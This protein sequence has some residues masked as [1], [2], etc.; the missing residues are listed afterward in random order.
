MLINEFRTLIKKHISE[1]LTCFQN[2]I[3]IKCIKCKGYRFLK[4]THI[5]LFLRSFISFVDN[6]IEIPGNQFA[7]LKEILMLFKFRKW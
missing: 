5:N 1:N 6:G 2:S 7:I 4:Q 3:L